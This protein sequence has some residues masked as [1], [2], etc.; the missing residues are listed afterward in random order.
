M[1]AGREWRPTERAK[2]LG[3]SKRNRCHRV[4][5]FLPGARGSRADLS[6]SPHR[7]FFEWQSVQSA[8]LRPCQVPHLA[9]RL[10]Q[11]RRAVADRLRAPVGRWPLLRGLSE[12]LPLMR[13][14][15]RRLEFEHPSGPTSSKHPYRQQ[16][17]KFCTDARAMRHSRLEWPSQCP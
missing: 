14:H 4:C 5:R 8:K 10:Q 9:T 7:L 15:R 6:D 12:R 1:A 16:E 11:V 13:Q 17:P 3:E 2:G